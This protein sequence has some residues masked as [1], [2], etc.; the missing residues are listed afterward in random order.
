[1]SKGLVTFWLVI[2]LGYAWSLVQLVAN[3]PFDALVL[4][5]VTFSFHSFRNAIIEEVK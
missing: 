5:I 2:V 1:M 3:E 4:F